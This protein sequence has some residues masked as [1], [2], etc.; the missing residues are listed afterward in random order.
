MQVSLQNSDEDDSASTAV[1]WLGASGHKEVWAFF[2]FLQDFDLNVR[3]VNL[4][5]ES[6]DDETGSGSGSESGSYT[7]SGSESGSS[8]DDFW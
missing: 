1:S 3:L 5:T 8:E 6:E 2:L 7:G 4:Q